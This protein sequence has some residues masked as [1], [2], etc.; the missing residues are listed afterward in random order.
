MVNEEI[1]T[2][3]DMQSVDFDKPHTSTPDIINAVIYI[4]DEDD[5]EATAAINNES[6]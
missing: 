4:D 3:V 5:S 6:I 2:R 1:N